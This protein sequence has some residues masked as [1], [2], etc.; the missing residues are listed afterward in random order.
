MP[1]ADQLLVESGLASSRTVA[2]RMIAA[3]RVSWSGGVIKKPALDLPLETALTVASDP[4]DR[5]ASR[6]GLKLAGALTKVAS[7]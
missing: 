5:S 3:G 7:R 1:R 4:E 6:G 2:Q